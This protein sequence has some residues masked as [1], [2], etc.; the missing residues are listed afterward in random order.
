MLYRII[1]LVLVLLFLPD[2]YIYWKYVRKW[3]RRCCL[4][5]LTFVPSAIL[6]VA[7]I[8][9]ISSNDMLPD[10][11]PYVGLFMTVMLLICAPKFIF[12]LID[13]IGNLFPSPRIRR[14]FRISGMAFAFFSLLIL[15]S[16]CFWGR[17]RFVV[18]RQTFY[19]TDLPK[20]FDGYRIAHFS[21][22]HIG[23][24]RQGHEDDAK[25]I[26]DLINDQRCDMIVFT[27]DLVNHQARE[28]DGFKHVLSQLAAPD[29]VYAIMGNHDYS[30]YIKYPKEEQRKADVADLQRRERSYGWNLL[31]NSHDII[32]RKK[33]SIAIIGVE[34]DGRPPF[35]SLGDLSKAT[36]GIKKGTFSVLLSHDPTHWR[37]EVLPKTD[38]QL[39][40]SGHTHAGQFKVF[41]WSPVAFV[42]DEWSG[43]YNE[44]RQILNVSDGIGTVLFPFRFGAWPEVNVITLKKID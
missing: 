19:F 14:T 33:D 2:F 27:G 11:Q 39:T 12:S 25:R 13:G 30:M 1:I 21:D 23:T 8:A 5:M 17:S 9:I 42:Y 37:R 22:M 43:A 29:G 40:L 20:E 28:L 24:L 6:M 38:I 26:V 34:N 44:G 4:R 16:G 35:P 36:K 15:C 41:G 10:N 18:H 7:M 32:Y 31:I 3:T